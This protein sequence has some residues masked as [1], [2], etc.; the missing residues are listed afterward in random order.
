MF[1]RRTLFSILLVLLAAGC[2]A[3]GTGEARTA[4]PGQVSPLPT[5]TP[6][7]GVSAPG[8]TDTPGVV[9]PS[10]PTATLTLTR[11]PA[12]TPPPAEPILYGP[13]LQDGAPGSLWVVWDTARPSTGWVTYAP[14]GG[15]PQLALEAAPARHHQLQLTGLADYAPYTYQVGGDPAPAAFTSPAGPAQT[16]FHFAVLG[17]TRA[18][19]PVHSAISQAIAAARPDLVLHTGDLVDDGANPGL[20]NA[21]LKI[22]EPMLRLAPFYPTLGNHE[23]NSPLY[24][25]LFHLPGGG[26]YYAFDHANA[27]FIVL[28]ADSYDPAPFAP[29]G[30][31]RAWLEQQL[32]GA[33]GRWIFVSFHVPL[34]TSFSE[35]PSEVGL[36][37][38]L[39]PLF[40]QYHVAVVF[41]GHIHS[42]ERVLA[43]GVASA[44]PW[45]VT[46][47]VTGGG[48]APL[49]SLDVR[50]PG[51]QAAALV[52]HYLLIEV[53]GNTLSARAISVDGKQI[54]AFTLQR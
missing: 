29:G 3:A 46:Y 48:G 35:D 41:G 37:R 51:Q 44:P 34:H 26:S 2:S 50:E 23:G 11:T 5:G 24:F 42:Y 36:R 8:A 52:Y 31:Q 6:R 30:G 47:V 54:D 18:N 38:Q 12:I 49:Y 16:G 25:Q 20:W 13:I 32:Q 21:F 28:K 43:G 14:A 45:G 19:P 7:R 10:L 9:T 40:E 15:P 1:H 27:R 17:D 22:E 33:A 53:S 39:A 4:L